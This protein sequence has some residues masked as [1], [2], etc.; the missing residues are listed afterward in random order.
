MNLY[1]ALYLVFLFVVLTPGVLLKIPPKG[2]KLVVAAVH[3]IIFAIVLCLTYNLISNATYVEH[4]DPNSSACVTA[5]NNYN[6]F[7][8]RPKR[9]EDAQQNAVKDKFFLDRM[10]KACQPPPPPPPSNLIG[11]SN[12]MLE[13]CR[14]LQRRVQQMGEKMRDPSLDSRMKEMIMKEVQDL[15]KQGEAKCRGVL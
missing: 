11:G 7:L 4:F 12:S 13:F 2:S 6:N 5:R 15:N 14:D 1:M 9:A 8:K 3:G 10:A